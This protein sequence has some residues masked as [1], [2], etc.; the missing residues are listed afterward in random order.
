M[1]FSLIRGAN[2]MQLIAYVF[3][4]AFVVFCTLPVHEFAHAF[5]ADKLGDNTPRIQGRLTLNP[6]KHLDLFGTLL[7]LKLE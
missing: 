5:A 2:M 7:I 4:M 3:S 1:L 6:L